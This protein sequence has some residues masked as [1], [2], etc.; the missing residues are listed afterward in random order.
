MKYDAIKYFYHNRSGIDIKMPYADSE[1]L[2]RGAGHRSDVM[3]NF[4]NTW[5]TNENK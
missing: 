1:E 4:P 3:P 5:Y 2:T